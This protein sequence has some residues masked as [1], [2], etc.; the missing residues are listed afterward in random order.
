MA[1]GARI[2]GDF[3][4]Q[5]AFDPVSL[6]SSIARCAESAYSISIVALRLWPSGISGL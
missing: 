2:P 4:I 1:F 5:L 3:G 6:A